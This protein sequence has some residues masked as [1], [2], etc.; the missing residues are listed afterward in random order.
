MEF[1]HFLSAYYPD[2]DYGGDRLYADMLAQARLADALGYASVSIPEHH[3]INILLTPAPLL[4]AVKLAAETQHAR[5]M[6]SVAVLPLHD[7]R[8]YAGEIVMADILTEGRLILGIGRG[9]F[10]VEQE[11]LGSPYAE[12]RAKFDESLAVLQ[13]LLAEEEVSWSGTYYDFEPITVMPRPV[14]PIQFMIAAVTPESIYHSARRGFHIQ[15]SPL[16][17]S[18]EK[19]LEQI[20]AF[21]RAKAE[22]GP[23]HDHL[24]LSLSRVAWL[25]VDDADKWR[26]VALAHEYYARFDNLFTGPGLVKNGA[27]EALPRAQSPEELAENLLICTAEEMVDKL[28]VYFEAGVDEVIFNQNIGT[29]NAETLDNMQQI[30]E[31]VMP[32][33]VG[34]HAA[35]R[36]AAAAE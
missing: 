27:A 5:L 11:R 18:R 16:M 26:K 34:R 8:T 21:H 20:D 23:S 25:A 17:A 13:K 7:M 9:A 15:T 3:L 19:M 6:T 4:M 33:F 22:M 36:G 14:R 35:P 1:N 12:S 10:A 30:A 31:E 24:T 28:G 2:T 32:H 29:A